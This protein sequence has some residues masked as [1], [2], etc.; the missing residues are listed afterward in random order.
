M[1]NCGAR[2][3]T[4]RDERG[5]H[6]DRLTPWD[7]LTLEAEAE[8]ASGA[9]PEKVGRDRGRDDKKGDRRGCCGFQPQFA[10]NHRPGPHPQRFWERRRGRGTKR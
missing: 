1:G 9:E 7:M 2:A 5:G 6:T 8:A 10:Q 3:G 4:R